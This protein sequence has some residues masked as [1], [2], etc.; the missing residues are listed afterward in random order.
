MTP[1]G[2]ILRAMVLSGG[3]AYAAYEVGVLKA[4]LGGE[5]P[6]TGYRPLDPDIYVGTSG[7]A[8][9]AAIMTSQPDQESRATVGFLESV[10]VDQFAADRASCRAGAVRVRG[11]I[12]QYADLSCFASNPVLPLSRFAE[13]ATFFATDFLTR[14]SYALSPPPRPL[15][16]R[17]LEFADTT[18]VVSNEVFVRVM[19]QMVD[20]Q[21]IRESDK[22]LGIATTNWRTGELRVFANADMSDQIGHEA[23]EASTAFPGLAPVLIDG[24]P[25]VDGGY[26]LNTPLQPAIAANG[27]E[28]HVVFMD[29]DIRNIPTR[30]FDNTFDVIDK[31]YH[32]TQAN[33]FKRDIGLARGINRG[34][35]VL[36]GAHLNPSQWSGVLTLLGHARWP[37]GLTETPF[38]QLTIHLYH[39]R[40][41]IGGALGLI[42]FDRGH[43]IDL[44]AKGYTDAVAHDC[45]ASGCVLPG[46]GV[47]GRS[48]PPSGTA[49]HTTQGVHAT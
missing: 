8:V 41:D 26:V 27:D 19:R 22:V 5:S 2:Q 25:Y 33:L 39:P 46:G 1:D 45:Q 18:M 12:A 29:P 7:G 20:L 49:P 23:I 16:R 15:A 3:S 47:G 13:D 14:A 35:N 6:A 28:L 30:R 37:K 38:R 44:I 17:A 4:L 10:W 34:L 43:I 24:E 9:N 31:F 36:M 42:N 40:E 21:G 11:D 48:I 32:I